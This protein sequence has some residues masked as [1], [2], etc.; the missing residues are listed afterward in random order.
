MNKLKKRNR[1]KIYQIGVDNPDN[2]GAILFPWVKYLHGGSVFSGIPPLNKFGGVS[3]LLNRK[4]GIP[5]VIDDEW[6]YIKT[7]RAA[8]NESDMEKHI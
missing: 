3:G 2:G 1:D 7:I 8:I 5:V 6:I 4:N